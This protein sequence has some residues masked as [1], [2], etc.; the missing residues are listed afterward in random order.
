MNEAIIGHKKVFF[1]KLKFFGANYTTN[2][3]HLL[4]L[5]VASSTL[6]SQ[7]VILTS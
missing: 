2:S 4:N 5:Q 1:P 6:G 7:K 3:S